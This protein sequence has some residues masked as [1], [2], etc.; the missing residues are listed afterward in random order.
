MK[1][2]TLTDD[3]FV[4]LL[5]VTRKARTFSDPF[6]ADLKRHLDGLDREAGLEEA[7]RHY[8]EEYQ[9][10]LLSEFNSFET[11]LEKIADDD[12]ETFNRELFEAMKAMKKIS[13]FM[14]YMTK[15]A[16][17]L[18]DKQVPTEEELRGPSNDEPMDET[19][20]G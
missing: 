9:K 2:D 15:E 6:E 17:K 12:L 14:S 20:Y 19:N 10:K 13:A 16:A 7:V 5:P 4:R 3:P 18:S 8:R 1:D 11:L